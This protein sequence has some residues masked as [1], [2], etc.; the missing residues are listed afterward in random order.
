MLAGIHRGSWK[1]TFE[2]RGRRKEWGGKEERKGKRK[3]KLNPIA[4][5]G[6]RKVHSRWKILWELEKNV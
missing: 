3:E 2:K 4:Y 1:L 6:I 5:R